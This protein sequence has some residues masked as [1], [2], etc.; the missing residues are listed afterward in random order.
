MKRLSLRMLLV[1]CLG[2]FSASNVFALELITGKPILIESTYMPG[3]LVFQMDVGT[4]T[5]G[6]GAFIFWQSNGENN[7]V[8]YSTVLTALTAGKNLNVYLDS[9]T[10]NAR[11]LH[12]H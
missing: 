6:A 5:C 2:F 10:C 8:T 1:G 3:L 12:I 7:K 4:S 9:G 11:Y